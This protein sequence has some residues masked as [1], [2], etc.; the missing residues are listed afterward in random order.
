MTSSNIYTVTITDNNGCV[1]TDSV[2]IEV[3]SIPDVQV[4]NITHPT[5]GLNDGSITFVFPDHPTKTSFQVSF[6]G[7]NNYEAP[8]AD[9]LGSYTFNNR[10]AGVYNI[11]VRWSDGDCPITIGSITLN[12]SQNVTASIT[13][14]SY[15]CIG[16]SI[17]LTANAQNGATP[18]IYT[19]LD[20]NNNTIG[21]SSTLNV[22]PTTNQQ[23]TLQVID[24]N[25]CVAYESQSI[26]ADSCGEI[27]NNGI[28]DDGDGLIDCDDYECKSGKIN[29]G[30]QED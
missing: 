22:S 17:T 30:I 29:G 5:C 16:S 11:F 28:D 23:Y 15:V 3:I 1:A 24:G 19:W 6:D 4:N 9:N 10:S 8:I 27:C 20:E 25:G 13:S 12:N 18:Y 2:T 14:E 21:N 7:G 26:V